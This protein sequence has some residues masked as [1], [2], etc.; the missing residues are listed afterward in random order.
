[1]SQVINN[2][3]DYE[4]Y[5]STQT[6]FTLKQS[7]GLTSKLVQGNMNVVQKNK[8]FYNNDLL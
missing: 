4:K 6:Y 3:P 8:V 1:M 5:G 2:L 7:A